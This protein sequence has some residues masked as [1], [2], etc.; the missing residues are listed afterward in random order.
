MAE[1][2]TR[3]RDNRKPYHRSSERKRQRSIIGWVGETMRGMFSAP[4][5]ISGM[6]GAEETEESG[7][8]LNEVPGGAENP[9]DVTGMIDVTLENYNEYYPVRNEICLSIT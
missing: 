8:S 6:F 2:H 3:S 9:I 4:L 1:K 5:W 7:S